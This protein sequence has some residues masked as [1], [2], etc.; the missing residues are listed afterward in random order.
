[1]H[2]FKS[3]LYGILQCTKL[4]YTVPYSSIANKCSAE[5]DL[6]DGRTSSDGVHDS[7]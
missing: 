4:F 3:V 5:G 2:L 1:V 7:C 6:S